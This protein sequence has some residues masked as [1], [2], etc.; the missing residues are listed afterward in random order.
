ML[1]EAV[2]GIVPFIKEDRAKPAAVVLDTE[3]EDSV[4]IIDTSGRQ[5]NNKNLMDELKKISNI[6]IKNQNQFVN[7]KTLLTLMQILD[8]LL[9]KL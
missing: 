8:L 2:Y 9:N 7:I 6:I 4:L 5:H 3:L 1:L